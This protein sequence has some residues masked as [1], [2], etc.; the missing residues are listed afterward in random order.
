MKVK[1]GHI[2]IAMLTIAVITGL[3]LF[4]RKKFSFKKRLVDIARAE[5]KKWAGLKET[6]PRVSK[7]LVEYWLT[8]GL[9]FSE[10]QMQSTSTHSTY[11][12]SSAFISAL[13]YK[14]GAKDKFPYGAAH[15]DYFQWAKKH[16]DNPK[17]PLRGFR[18][19][20]Y[21]PKVGDLLVFSRKTGLGYDTPGFFPSHGELVI[22]KGAG[23]VETIGGNVSNTVKISRFTVDSKGFITRNERDFF[24]VIQNNI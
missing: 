10:K 22:G 3:I 7:Y 24:M 11:P 4:L 5:A 13:F 8:V 6:N 23:Y 15:N 9:S 2:A 17:S 20:E 14:A 1:I 12:W 18:I 16:R 21:A 19:N